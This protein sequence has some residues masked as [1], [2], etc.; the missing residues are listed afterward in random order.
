MSEQKPQLQPHAKE[1]AP[2]ESLRGIV[3]IAGVDVKGEKKLFV[4][5]KRIKGIGFTLAGAICK[6]SGI[7]RNK[8]VGALTEDEVKKL[9]EIMNNLSK[10]GVQ[11]WL[12]NRRK[13][14][15]TGEDKHL[16][17]STYKFTLEQDIKKMIESKSYKG[18]RH[19][20]GLPV[21]GQRTRSSFRK[22][23]SMGVVRKK[24]QPAK[25]GAKK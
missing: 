7:D 17:T 5:L 13:D 15:E 23:K 16:I 11:T 19:A 4:S 21:R 20:L 9:E 3:R 1:T 22:G 14:P 24:L 10:Y 8:K 6:I 2:K 12:L 18:V 25:A